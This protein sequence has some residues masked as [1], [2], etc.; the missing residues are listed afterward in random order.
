[1]IL[2][3]KHKG[4]KNFYFTGALSGIIPQHSNRLKLILQLLNAAIKPDNMNLP[5]LKFHRLGGS[6]K[7]YYSVTVSAN[8]RVIFKFENEDAILV[9]YLD[10]H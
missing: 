1:M 9:D 2:S 5:G 10:Y 7:Q 6:L 4:L 8:W 3:W